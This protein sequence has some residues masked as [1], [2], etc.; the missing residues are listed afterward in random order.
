M[1]QALKARAADLKR[2][3]NALSRPSG[4]TNARRL[5][6]RGESLDSIVF[7]DAVAADIPALAELH[8]TTAYV[9]RNVE[10]SS[11]ESA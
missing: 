10:R 8:V 3:L 6:A 4:K 9:W 2:W 11:G 5:R 1:R 7:R